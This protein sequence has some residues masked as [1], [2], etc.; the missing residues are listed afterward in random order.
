MPIATTFMAPCTLHVRTV[1]WRMNGTQKH[2]QV[3]DWRCGAVR[4]ATHVPRH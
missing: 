4:Y 1:H 3:A 2:I